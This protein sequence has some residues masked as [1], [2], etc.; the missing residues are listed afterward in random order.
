MKKRSSV[1]QAEPNIRIEKIKEKSKVY[2]TYFV[3]QFKNPSRAFEQG[4]KDFSNG[5]IS[6][7]LFA[8]VYTVS[9]YLVVNRNYFGESLG[10]FPFFFQIMLLVFLLF[11][12]AVFALFIPNNFF[13]SPNSLKTIISFYGGQLS[14]VVVSVGVAFLLMVIQSFTYGQLVL[15]VS[16]VFG[17][18]VLPL[19]LVSFLA[20][21]K[22]PGLDPLYGFILYILV[23]V[24]LFL[25]LLT[26]LAGTMLGT[27]LDRM[28]YLI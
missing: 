2:R 13:G 26:I 7:L 28:I 27:Y 11:G 1:Q 16:F 8:I 6:I 12:I 23:F 20:T 22:V 17:L 10:F 5:L 19:Y 24:L 3:Q 9:L 25:I 18:F 14:P 15:V 4:E 21:K